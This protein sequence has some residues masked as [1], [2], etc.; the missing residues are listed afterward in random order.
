M[1]RLLAR[2]LSNK[3]IAQ[4]LV[5]SPK[6]AGSHVEHIYAQDRRLQPRAGQPVRDASRADARRA[7]TRRRLDLSESARSQRSGECPMIDPVASLPASIEPARRTRWKPRRSTGTLRSR[8]RHRHPLPRPGRAASR[9]VLLHGGLVST[10]PIWTGVPVAYAGHMDT[11]AEHFRVIAPDTRGCGRTVHPG[12]ADQLRSAGRRR[13]RDDRRARTRAA[14]DR[15]LQ[16][17]RD[18]RDH[19]RHPAPRHGPSDRQS[20]GLRR[21]RSRGPDVRDDAPDPR[22]QPRCDRARSGRGRA[23]VRGLRADAPAC[24]S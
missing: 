12:G 10:N 5:I 8:Q 16:R 11:L 1:L 9:F 4:Q 22:R 20:R 13:R 23:R 19:P 15:R 17:G 14:P 6:T 18:H 7:G 3:Q 24:S 21:V 2:G